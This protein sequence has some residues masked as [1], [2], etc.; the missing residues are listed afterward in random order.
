[1]SNPDSTKNWRVRLFTQKRSL[2]AG[3]NVLDRN[4]YISAD[5][6]KNGDHSVKTIDN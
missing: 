6:K 5:I 1:M 4:L 3:L 2:H